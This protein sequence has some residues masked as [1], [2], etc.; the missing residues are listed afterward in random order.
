[1]K[2]NYSKMIRSIIN[3]RKRLIDLK[4]NGKNI[5]LCFRYIKEL[6]DQIDYSGKNWTEDGW[7]RF[8]QRNIDK[9]EYLVPDSKAGKTIKEKLYSIK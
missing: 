9:I 5:T 8:I 1:M 7:K 2:T 3:Q 4:V 6:S